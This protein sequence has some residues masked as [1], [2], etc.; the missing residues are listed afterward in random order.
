MRMQQHR[1]LQIL[2]G[3]LQM[4]IR[5]IIVGGGIAGLSTYL[6]LRK[7]LPE[8]VE[9]SITI[10]ESHRPRP[11]SSS[12]STPNHPN[13]SVSLD[14]LSESTAVV[15]GGLGISPNGMRVLHDLS[16]DLHD[17]VV[18][19]GFSANNFIFKGANNWTLGMHSTSDK[20]LRSQDNTEEVCIASSRHGLW[21]TLRQYT[22]DKY[23]PDVI[24]HG[25]VTEVTR[26]NAELGGRVR[27]EIINELGQTG[28]EFA[29]LVIGADGI[30]S[31]VRRA[32]FGDDQQYNPTYR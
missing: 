17:R 29:D 28:T 22:L 32:L 26:V 27:V 23:G 2:H 21:H 18:A 7:H 19:Q 4:A 14:A 8:H 3:L 5:I 13:Q 31:V 20:D 11:A 25:K 12:A 15:G 24:K 1:T 16:L 30:K 9:H 10:Y 6:H